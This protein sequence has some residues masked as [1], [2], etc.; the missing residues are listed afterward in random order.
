MRTR[1][2]GKKNGEQSRP[3]MEKQK[4]RPRSGEINKDTEGNGGGE[5]RS[6]EAEENPDLN[7]HSQRETAKGELW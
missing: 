2:A 4:E 6:R 3:G 1:T 7:T 5:K